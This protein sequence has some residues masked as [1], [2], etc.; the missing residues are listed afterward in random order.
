[1]ILGLRAYGLGP[2]APVQGTDF[3][4]R[5]AGDC[6]R[7]RRADRA[8]RARPAR[9]QRTGASPPRRSP[10]RPTCRR[11]TARRW[12]AMRSSRRTPSAPGAP[13][14]ALLRLVDRV[15]TGQVPARA[16]AR[17]ECIE[18][19]TGAPMPRGADAVVMVE[20]TEAGG[21]ETIHVLTPVN[22]GQHVGR[23]G[24]DISAGRPVVERGTLINPS[25]VGAIA[26]PRRGRARCLRPA[27]RGDP[28][29]RQ[30][31]RRSR[32]SARTGTDLRHQPVHAGGRHRPARRRRRSSF[33]GAR[34]APGA[35]RRPRG[36]ACRR[37][38]RVLRRQLR[39]RARSPDRYPPEPGRRAL[40]RDRGQA[41]QADG[42]RPRETE[43]DLRHAGLPDVL[44]LERVRPARADPQAHGAAAGHSPPGRYRLAW[45]GGSPRRPAGISSIPCG[46]RGTSR[47]R[48][49]RRPATSRACRRPMA[50]SRSRP[51]PTASRRGRSST[52]DCFSHFFLDT[53]SILGYC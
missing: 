52:S 21:D 44:P 25:R 40:S 50:T 51:T 5:R 17:G 39:R 4:R 12:T 11:S 29:D 30:R 14:R 26:A 20:E 28:F 33:R 2:Y 32:Q 53:G 38:R 22:P 19:A 3:G 1:M 47:T 23:R 42:V 10:R 9:P 27:A 43:A 37:H 45:R 31:A 36:G 48:R 41:G 49:S 6:R 46:S 13:S 35:Q 7:L 34:H 24:A 18:I 15:Y 16:L 8:N